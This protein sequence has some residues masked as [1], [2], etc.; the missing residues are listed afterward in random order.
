MLEPPGETPAPTVTVAPSFACSSV[1]R[2]VISFVMLAMGRRSRAWYAAIVS[3]LDA[4]S[5]KYAR[6]CTDGGAATA[7]AASASA[8]TTAGTRTRI[9]KGLSVLRRRGYLPARGSLN[10]GAEPRRLG[11]RGGPPAGAAAGAPPVGVALAG[12]VDDG[13]RG[14]DEGA[15]RPAR[16]GA[17]DVGT[18]RALRADAREQEEGARH[19]PARLADRSR[20]G[21]PD[22]GADAREPALTD[23]VLAPLVHV[24][25]DVVPERPAVRELRVLHVGRAGVRRL[26]E[27]EEPAAVAPARGEERLDRVAAEVRVD[28]QRVAERHAALPRLEVGGRIGTRRRCNVAALRVHDDEE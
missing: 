11:G 6:A 28:G 8:A 17:G 21:G 19:Q 20:V 9:R 7:G 16:E 22:H 2:T 27:A 12:G 3:P 18:G 10:V 26:D 24:R 23:D 1:R 5:M 15:R 14:R 25:R 4:F 13:T